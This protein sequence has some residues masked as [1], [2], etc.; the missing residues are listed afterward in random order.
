MAVLSEADRVDAW[1]SWMQDNPDDTPFAKQ[2]LRDA[3]NA[4]DNWIQANQASFVAALPE[5]FS[6]QSTLDQKVRLFTYVVA[7]RWEV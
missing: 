5:P 2:E 1:A 6:S 7:K 3:L 4:T